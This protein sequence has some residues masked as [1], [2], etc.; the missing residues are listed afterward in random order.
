MSK[1]FH[2]LVHPSQTTDHELN[3]I[4]E[5][6]IENSCKV[7][8]G[9]NNTQETI[10]ELEDTSY[11]NDLEPETIIVLGGQRRDFCVS[12]HYTNLLDH[13][14]IRNGDKTVEIDINATR[15][16]HLYSLE[17]EARDKG[18]QLIKRQ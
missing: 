4:W 3:T 15:G 1:E 2:V 8:H 9:S 17:K 18:F 14:D 6:W 7:L 11:V 13:P 5:Q 10:L 16:G 12:V